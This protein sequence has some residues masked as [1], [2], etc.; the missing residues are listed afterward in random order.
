MDNHTLQTF[1]SKSAGEYKYGFRLIKNKH[2]T[3]FYSDSKEKLN[4]WFNKIKK[5]CILNNFFND[6]TAVGVL[7]KGNFAKV[8]KVKSKNTGKFFAAKIFEK[9]EVSKSDK[10]RKALLSELKIMRMVDH[11]YILKMHQ[12]YEGDQHIYIV[13]DIMYGRELFDRVLSQKYYSEENSAKVLK[14]LLEILKY[15]EKKEILHRDIKLENILLEFEDD[16]VNIKLADFGLSTLVKD[17]DP[18]VRCGTP[19]YVAPEVLCDKAYD[20][21]SDI[22]SAGVALFIL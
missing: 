18:T 14:R 9:T 20:F 8:Y 10:L 6:F 1:E 7:G 2:Y 22:F 16:D 3:E 15:L 17:L 13:F 19:G 5:H 11:P 12:V 4:I 21:K